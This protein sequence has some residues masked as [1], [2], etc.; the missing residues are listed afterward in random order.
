MIN[1]LLIS[2][3]LT[4]IDVVKLTWVPGSLRSKTDA[5]YA[6]CPNSGRYSSTFTT[7]TVTVVVTA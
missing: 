5:V 6:C 1:I 7:A 3:I 2:T 4:D